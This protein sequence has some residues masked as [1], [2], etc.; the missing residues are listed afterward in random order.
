MMH[1][2]LRHLPAVFW[3][4]R[5]LHLTLFVTRRCNAQCP[6]CFYLAA[7]GGEPAPADELS[8]DEYER[9]APTVGPLLWL[10]FSG[11]EPVLRRDLADIAG[12]FARH[13]HP[14]FLTLP[15]NGLLP[16]A[17]AAMAETILA[18]CPDSTLVVKVSI[19]GVGEEHDALRGVP[20]A[21]DKTVA[22]CRLLADLARRQ[23]R[24]QLGVNTV[25]T[26][27][28]HETINRLVDE[29]AAMDGVRGHTISL[30]RG[31]LAAQHHLDVPPQAFRE[32]QDHLRRVGRTRRY[33]FRGGRLKAAEEQ[34]RA[35]LV[36]EIVATGRSPL[37][38]HAGRLS[39]VLSETGELFPC[40]MTGQSFGN[41]RD[42]GYDL[43]QVLA[44]ERA[45]DGL[46]RI[47]AGCACT[48]ECALML[49]ILFSP[50]AYP[51]LL[52]GLIGA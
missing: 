28:N 47:D 21:Y 6:Y 12:L 25:L 24:L 18:A 19:D 13:C 51:R 49:N 1:T 50:A 52:R 36:A 30:V 11:G 46:C 43:R 9:L 16:E 14:S 48:H 37:P 32:A 2:P 40:E 42:Y 3:K 35:E 23:P 39:V 15:T 20:G 22:T 38:C 34:M 26:A 8:L 7:A 10:A 31:Q 33:S 29:V 41:L 27:A 44:T 17:T 5:P 45:R 4:R